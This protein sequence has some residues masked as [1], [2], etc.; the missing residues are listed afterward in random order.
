MS[1]LD[2]ALHNLGVNQTYETTIKY[3]DH[4]KPYG[5]NIKVYPNRIVLGLSRSWKQ[6]S[7]EIKVGLAQE[8]LV[9]VFRIK[10]TTLNMELYNGFIKN[11]HIAIPKEEPEPRLLASFNHVNEK[12]FNDMIERPNIVW[13][14]FTTRKLGSYD[15]RQDTITMSRVL[16]KEEKFIDLV[17]H[18]ELL[19]KKHKFSSKN[20][21]SLHHSSAFKREEHS[22]ENYEELEKQ[23]KNY[24]MK[25]NLRKMFKF[26]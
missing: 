15:Y 16:E 13:G 8:L 18:H 2:E 12:Y 11:I 7:D 22:F 14:D 1:F 24:L 4:F 3:S 17:M 20:G 26:W 23:L 21:R 10:K 6:I 9:K 19:H 25:A 5:S